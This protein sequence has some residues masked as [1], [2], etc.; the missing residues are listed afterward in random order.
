MGVRPT[1]VAAGSVV[2]NL[3][4]EEFT[5]EGESAP[6]DCRIG[7]DAPYAAL[8]GVRKG[9]GALGSIAEVDAQVIGER[10]CP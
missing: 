2:F 9:C 5:N 3:L 6:V 1:P 8:L 4:E 10:F 7:V